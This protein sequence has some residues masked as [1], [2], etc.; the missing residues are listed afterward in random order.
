MGASCSTRADRSVMVDSTSAAAFEQAPGPAQ[1]GSISVLESVHIE[2]TDD[3][4]CPAAAEMLEIL[5]TSAALSAMPSVRKLALRESLRSATTSE[6]VV[7]I[8]VENVSD[9]PFVPS[10]ARNQLAELLFAGNFDAM[11]QAL[12]CRSTT[13]AAAPSSAGRDYGFENF[14]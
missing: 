6:A 1:P 3:P 11:R 2:E 8:A 5:S 7:A 13:A 4:I 10:H 14:P 12:Q 9:S